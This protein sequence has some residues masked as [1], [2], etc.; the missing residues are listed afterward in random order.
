MRYDRN[1]FL[2]D[3][4]IPVKGRT[5]KLSKTMG[6][7]DNTWI[8][9]GSGEVLATHLTT[10]KKVDTQKFVKLFTDNIGLTFGLKP[11][12]VKVFSMLAWCVQKDSM[13]KDLVALDHISL[14]FFCAST[15]NKFSKSTLT[16]GLGELEA[17]KI[18]AKSSRKGHYFIN[19]SFIFN[20]DRIAFSEVIE[21]DSSLDSHGED[22][23]L[24]EN[25]G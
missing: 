19:P 21:R 2:E 9:Q 20:G 8:N 7:D 5:V 10:Y 17:C 15:G 22:G 13:N 6:R 1:P 3:M 25:A 23:N 11:S 14:R 12:G 16:R 4:L 24:L 18:I